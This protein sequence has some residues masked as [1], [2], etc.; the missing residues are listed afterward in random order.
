MVSWFFE[1]CLPKF[2]LVSHAT[3]PGTLSL[4]EIFKFGRTFSE[5][6]TLCTP[7]RD[8]N[9]LLWTTYTYSIF[10]FEWSNFKPLSCLKNT[11]LAFDSFAMRN[12][13]DEI[14]TAK[15]RLSSRYNNIRIFSCYLTS[16]GRLLSLFWIAQKWYP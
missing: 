3:P 2:F 6:S 10:S 11:L 12:D 5:V 15:N 16:F 4:I 13:V 14:R 7:R 9:D 8:A 1:A